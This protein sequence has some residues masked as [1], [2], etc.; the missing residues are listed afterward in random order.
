M[1]F[2]YVPVRLL[3]MRRIFTTHFIVLSII[4]LLAVGLRLYFFVG[5]GPRDDIAYI[6]SAQAIQTDQFNLPHPD[7]S[8]IFPVRMMV[9]LPVFLSWKLF[10]ISEFSSCLYFI[11]CS[12]IMILTGYFMGKVLYGPIEGIIAALILAL[13]PLDLVFSSQ[14]MP[15][16]PQTVLGSSAILFFLVGKKSK[17]SL[18]FILSGT[19]MALSLM[20]KEFAIIYYIVL[21]FFLG[22]AVNKSDWK[23]A[24]AVSALALIMV[25][26]AVVLFLFWLP[27]LMENIPWAPIKVILNNARE[28]KNANPD[29][30]FY[31]KVMFNLYQHPWST[32]YFGIL[33]YLVVLSLVYIAVKDIRVSGPVVCWLVLYLLFIQWIGPW[34]A[35]RTA[36]ERM[37]R[38]LL[39]VS[40]PAVLICSRSLGIIWKSRPPFAKGVAVVT[41]IIL[42]SSFL[43]TTVRFA[44]PSES[45]HLWDLKETARLL[46]R[47]SGHPLYAD[48]GSAH[49]LKFLTSYMYD[50]REYPPQR[51]NFTSLSQCWVAFDI[52]DE[53]FLKKWIPLREI[54]DNWTEAFHIR[55]PHVAHFRYYDARIY[56]AP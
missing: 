17:N 10:G 56:W 12:L 13:L 6:T 47:L 8:L 21:L 44:Y 51:K 20:T 29:N 38:F 36:C 42:L 1:L 41:M 15:D 22:F 23:R 34:L 49:K 24:Q 55:G 39:P 53:A 35:G 18:F 16:L 30:W 9:Y 14:I 5:M 46:P 40:L 50:I 32:R 3:N 26:S 11:F 37:E 4:L 25:S 28:V 31:V 45:I 19:V 7:S 27:Y 48:S 54:P 52:S 2:S 33:Y 43:S